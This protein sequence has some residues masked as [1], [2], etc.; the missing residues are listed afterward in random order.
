M[1][2]TLAVRQSRVVP[3]GVDAAFAGTLPI[4]LT[5]I[6]S[7]WYGPIGPIKEVRDQH[8]EWGTTGQ[9]RTVMLSPTGS[10]REQLTRV[11]PPHAFGYALTDVT[12]PLGLL[13]GMAE[14]EWTFVPSGAATT[15]S[16]SWNIHAA[17]RVAGPL[18]P[19]LGRV[20]KGYARQSLATLAAEL[21]R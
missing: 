10:F 1:A 3:V 6:F 2:R 15:I 20:W 21:S 7:R 12:G 4:P 11:D 5:T 18:L 9:T 14:G 19:V 17:S 8:G 16:W 13:V